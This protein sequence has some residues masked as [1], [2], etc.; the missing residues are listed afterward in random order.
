MISLDQLMKLIE[1]SLDDNEFYE[2][3]KLI[4]RAKTIEPNNPV[5]LYLHALLFIETERFE[6]AVTQLKQIIENKHGEPMIYLTLAD[7]YQKYLDDPA[8][9]LQ[10]LEKYAVYNVDDTIKKRMEYLRTVLSE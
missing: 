10:Y 7:I 5:L 6:D 9:A 3:E 2:A 8:Q 4:Q 1:N